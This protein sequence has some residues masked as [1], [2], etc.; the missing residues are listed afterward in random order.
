MD[1]GD[2]IEGMA[3]EGDEFSVASIVC[4]TRD[5]ELAIVVAQAGEEIDVRWFSKPLEIHRGKA[6]DFAP[7][8]GR[9]LACVG[10]VADSLESDESHMAKAIAQVGELFTALPPDFID[11]IRGTYEIS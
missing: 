9:R 11:L 6:I 2:G 7:V 8:D 5:G 10:F 4:D 1:I 3:F